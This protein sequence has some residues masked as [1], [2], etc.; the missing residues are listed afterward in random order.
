MDGP[1]NEERLSDYSEF[2]W[3]AVLRENTLEVAVEAEAG[4]KR[5]A[6]G[7]ESVKPVSVLLRLPKKIVDEAV[8][9]EA[10]HAECCRKT[11]CD[12]P[13]MPV[14]EPWSEARKNGLQKEV[15]ECVERVTK[16]AVNQGLIYQLQA[17]ILKSGVTSEL[18]G[19]IERAWEEGLRQ[20]H[21]ASLKDDAKVLARNKKS[22]LTA[23]GRQLKKLRKEEG[24][25]IEEQL[26]KLWDCPEDR[27]K[28]ALVTCPP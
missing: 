17:A 6:V 8:A 19:E 22:S 12:L 4:F 2:A 24:I 26:R 20:H 14:P 1:N 10:K 23:T 3:Q 9:F 25:T 28:I 21:I 18:L 27:L 15:F 7:E 16:Q 5:V 13:T 11:K